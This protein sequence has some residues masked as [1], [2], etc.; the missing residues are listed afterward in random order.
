MES[1]TGHG[2]QILK[3]RRLLEDKWFWIGTSGVW[4]KRFESLAQSQPSEIF[5][6]TLKELFFSSPW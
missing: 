1:G 2:P 4:G 6:K 3:R 5:G